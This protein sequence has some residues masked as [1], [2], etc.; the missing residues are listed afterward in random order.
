[1][2]A[3]VR[4]ITRTPH[5]HR[6]S[7]C[8]PKANTNCVEVAHLAAHVLVRDSKGEVVLNAFDP[9]PWKAFL[10]TFRTTH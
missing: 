8:G 5:W 3:D 10:T 9:A 1:M 6:S 2:A 7:R 4:D